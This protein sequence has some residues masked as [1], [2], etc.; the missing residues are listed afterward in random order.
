M[1]K[2]MTR[3]QAINFLRFHPVKFGQMLG[4]TKLTDFHNGWIKKMAFGKDDYTLQ[5]HRASFKTTCLSVALSLI[6]ILL[7]N[8]RTLFM[9][10][11]DYDV[12]EIIK[13]VRNILLN[14]RTQYME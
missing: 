6:I 7:P 11:T 8:K 10:K 5:G 9:R 13:Q 3:E 2:K 4:F 1:L 12:K 14:P